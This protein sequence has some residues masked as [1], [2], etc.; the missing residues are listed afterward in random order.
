MAGTDGRTGGSLGREGVPG[1][2]RGR[3]PFSKTLENRNC[4]DVPGVILTSRFSMLLQIT[5]QSGCPGLRGGMS[6]GHCVV[7]RWF[8]LSL[9]DC[10]QAPLQKLFSLGRRAG[11]AE[12]V[13]PLQ[14]EVVDWSCR[15]LAQPTGTRPKHTDLTAD[16]RANPQH[17][18]L[19]H[20]KARRKRHAGCSD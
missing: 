2:C 4:E 19:K 3:Q 13:C 7:E 14:R 5:V 11:R 6:T 20:P 17:F 15:G 16:A 9:G 12:G 10:S 18:R 8:G 1:G